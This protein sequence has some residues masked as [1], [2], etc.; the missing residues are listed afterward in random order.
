VAICAVGV[1]RRQAEAGLVRHEQDLRSVCGPYGVGRSKAA[2]VVVGEVGELLAVG[3]DS[4][5]VAIGPSLGRGLE[6]D[7][8]AVW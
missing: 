5:N 4:K 3:V 2:A 7:L 8:G 6:G 1:H